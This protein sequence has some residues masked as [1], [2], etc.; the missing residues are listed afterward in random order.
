MT[1]RREKIRP[2]DLTPCIFPAIFL[3]KSDMVTK[4]HMASTRYL[5]C[6]AAPLSNQDINT[7]TEK[8]P[9]SRVFDL[10]I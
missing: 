8:F 9:V 1:A 2:K 3:G 7:L 5:L 6:A 10:I 4:E